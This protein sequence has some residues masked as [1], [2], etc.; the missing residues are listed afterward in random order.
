M[1][2][3]KTQKVSTLAIDIGGSGLKASVLD[4][5]GEMLCE[6]VRVDTPHPC[7]PAV[8]V[9]ALAKL[10]APLPAFDRISVGFPGVIRRGKVITAPNL[11]TDVFAGFDLAAALDATLGKPVRA[12]NDADMQGLAVVAGLGVEM[13]VTLGTGFGTALFVEGLLNAHLEVSHQP[14]RK[15]ETYDEQIGEAARAKVGNKKWSRRV[16]QALVN[17]RSLVN[18]DTFYVGGGNARR[19]DFDL[20]RDCKLIDNTAGILGGIRLWSDAHSVV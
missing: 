14:F 9:E 7:S 13:V 16:E 10:V 18:F 20:P 2:R 19:I 5:A 12:V 17:V 4:T 11:G 1:N 15:G 6:R 8:L 3:T